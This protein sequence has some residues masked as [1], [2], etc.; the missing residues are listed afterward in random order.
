[1]FGQS[2]CSSKGSNQ[3]EGPI[4]RGGEV[5]RRGVANSV[6]LLEGIMEP[7]KQYGAVTVRRELVSFVLWMEIDK[8]HPYWKTEL[9]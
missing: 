9:T 5:S 7:L 6:T 4:L 3:Q 2:R 1:M 8:K